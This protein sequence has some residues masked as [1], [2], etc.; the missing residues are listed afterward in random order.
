[1][2]C[3]CHT[4]KRRLPALFSP[5]LFL[6]TFSPALGDSIPISTIEELFEYGTASLNNPPNYNAQDYHL[7]NDIDASVTAEWWGTGIG[8]YP[9]WQTGYRGT[10]EGNGYTISNLTIGRPLDEKLTVDPQFGLSKTGS[11]LFGAIAEGGV[12]RNLTLENVSQDYFGD[13]GAL[14][15]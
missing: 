7:T 14:A 10:F 8:P 12:V 2:I 5:L 6:I 1:M 15:G 3:N 9:L 4:W 11:A 13:I